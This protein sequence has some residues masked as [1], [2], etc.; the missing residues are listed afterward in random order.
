MRYP[1]LW[2]VVL[3]IAAAAAWADDNSLHYNLYHLN[4]TAEQEVAN[5]TLTVNL[6]A[7]HQAPQA[8]EAAKVV[9]ERMAAAIK[10]AKKVASVQVQ[11][12][13]YRT[14]AV[15]KNQRIIAW[16]AVQQLQLKSQNF[17]DLSE[18][19]GQLQADL[20]TGAMQFS[21][22]ADTR[23]KITDTLTREALAK[24]QARAALVQSTMKARQYE[25]VSVQ[26]GDQGYQPPLHSGGM[27]REM[28]MMAADVPPPTL[29]AGTSKI[30]VSVSGQIQLA[31]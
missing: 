21:I 28:A 5:D 12:G 14:H 24:F 1:Y 15:Y 16:R 23:D 8:T 7:S 30:T 22:S 10:Q 18:L 29:E 19:V 25:V 6:S 3:M 9:N 27:R 4:V 20:Q 2:A 13:N 17:T 26:I 11:T 31:Y